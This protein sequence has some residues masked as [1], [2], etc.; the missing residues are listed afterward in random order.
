MSL[1]AATIYQIIKGCKANQPSAQKQLV[2]GFAP[3]L[4]SVAR[5]FC[6]DRPTAEDVL[7][8]SFI[9]IFKHIQQFDAEL[10]GIQTWMKKIVINTSLKYYRQKHVRLEISTENIL[11]E[12]MVLPEIFERLHFEE[13]LKCIQKLPV[14]YKE[15]FNLYVFDDYSHDEIAVL[16]GITA[17]A[18]RSQLS[19]A[20]KILK[21]QVQTL[22]NELERI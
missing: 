8:E 7:Q 21:E 2:V 10:S 15:V 20:R 5:R 12:Q 14:G 6:P 9:L 16:L 18:S 1:D 22:T 19:R 17:S 11:E 4:L 13:I 3:L